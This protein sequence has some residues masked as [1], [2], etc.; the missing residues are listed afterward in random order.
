MECR[1]KP[2]TDLAF[3]KMMVEKFG[4]DKL[5]LGEKLAVAFVIKLA[6]RE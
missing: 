3:L 2:C 1:Q 5:A 4:R 6:G